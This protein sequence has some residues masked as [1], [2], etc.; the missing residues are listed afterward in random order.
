MCQAL[1]GQGSGDQSDE[2]NLSFLSRNL[3]VNKYSPTQQSAGD[4]NGMRPEAGS[5]TF[6]FSCAV[7]I[8]DF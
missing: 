7:E 6:Y 8:L 3:E 1:G 2:Y 5:N 4:M